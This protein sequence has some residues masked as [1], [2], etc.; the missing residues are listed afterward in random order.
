[1]E[2]AN[3]PTTEP[4]TIIGPCEILE[5]IAQGSM[6][7]VYKARNTRLDVIRALKVLLPE[8]ESEA[9]SGQGTP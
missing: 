7:I 2:P 3:A 6:A 5:T 8:N 4:T 9:D 1:M